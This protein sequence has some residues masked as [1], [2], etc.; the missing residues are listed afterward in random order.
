M[1]VYIFFE[2]TQVDSDA[3]SV[4]IFL[5]SPRLIVGDRVAQSLVFCAVLCRPMFD[6]FLQCIVCPFDIRLPMTP[7][8]PSSFSCYLQLKYVIIFHH[9][10]VLKHFRSFF[11]GSIVACYILSKGTILC[12]CDRYLW[13][14]I[15]FLCHICFLPNIFIYLFIYLF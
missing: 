7:L 6:L 14:S 1:S 3:L 12:N 13:S 9:T 11:P 2:F 10:L 5:S 15:Y 4:Y 8:V